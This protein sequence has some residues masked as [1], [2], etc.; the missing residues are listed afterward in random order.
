[1]T[2]DVS[3]S[4]TEDVDRQTPLFR[5]YGGSW[6]EEHTCLK[7]RL[8][9][10]LGSNSP[11]N[12]IHKVASPRKSLGLTL[13][14]WT[15]SLRHLTTSQSWQT[16]INRLQVTR[17][18]EVLHDIRLFAEQYLSV[19]GCNLFEN[20]PPLQILRVPLVAMRILH[21]LPVALG[22]HKHGGDLLPRGVKS[23]CSASLPSP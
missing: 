14:H 21:L 22:K 9:R 19:L 20:P 16:I 5:R 2:I 11:L 4:Y 7:G 8:M 13:S 1:M 17:S 18:P 10:G 6:S 3:E 12:N 23:P 15:F